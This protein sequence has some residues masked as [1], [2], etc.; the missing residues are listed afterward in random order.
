MNTYTFNEE[1][2]LAFQTLHRYWTEHYPQASLILST[3]PQILDEHGI[4]GV[5][6]VG[7]S[8]TRTNVN[9]LL[10][11]CLISTRLT[12][13]DYSEDELEDFLPIARTTKLGRQLELYSEIGRR[14][15]Q[16]QTT[17]PLGQI[18]ADLSILAHM[19][20]KKLLKISERSHKLLTALGG[21]KDFQR[22]S[23]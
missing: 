3:Q 19:E 2:Q 13:I 5:V 20:P 8:S 6:I 23:P 14:I 17:R 21:V 15:Q 22:I 9:D 7:T 4:H 10:T 18:M 12:A 16:Q 1:V 11:D